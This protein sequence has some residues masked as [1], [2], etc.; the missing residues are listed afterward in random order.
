VLVSPSFQ[1]LTVDE[2]Y[3]LQ[4]YR[5]WVDIV[6]ALGKKQASRA[7]AL[8]RD[9]LE[10]FSRYHHGHR[11]FFDGNSWRIAARGRKAN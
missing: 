2:D 6:K 5:D 11:E 8:M 3:L 7:R 1:F 4:A 9:H 10:R